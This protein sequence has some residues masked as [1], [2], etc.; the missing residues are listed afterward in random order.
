M[1]VPHSGECAAGCDTPCAWAPPPG[2]KNLLEEEAIV[3]GGTNH[4]HAE[5]DLQQAIAAGAASAMFQACATL[6]LRQ[7]VHATT[8][9]PS[10]PLFGHAQ[11]MMHTLVVLPVLCCVTC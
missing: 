5:A 3:V 9:M 6:V 4:S 2:V 8:L 10:G 11:Y 1:R 7:N